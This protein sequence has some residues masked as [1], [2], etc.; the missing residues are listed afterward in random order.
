VVSGCSIPVILSPDPPDVRERAAE[1]STTEDCPSYIW[2]TLDGVGAVGLGVWTGFGVDRAVTAD[3]ATDRRGAVAQSLTTGLLTL[4]Y[5]FFSSVG[6]SVAASC[7]SAPR[8]GDGR[9]P[10]NPGLESPDA[11]DSS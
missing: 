11:D 1:D 6:L 9:A 7:R 10:S 5:G 2:G 8:E 4:G 3:T